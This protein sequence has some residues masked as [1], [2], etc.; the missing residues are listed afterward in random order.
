MLPY[1]APP[2]IRAVSSLSLLVP[3]VPCPACTAAKPRSG[4]PRL[5]SPNLSLVRNA[6]HAAEGRANG[7]K[8][9]PGKRLGAKKTGDEYVIPGNI[10]FRQRGTNWHAGANCALGRDHTV[11]ATQPGYVRYYRNPSIHPTRRYI[12]V[13][14]EKHH[15]LPKPVNAARKR[16]LGMVAIKRRDSETAA[17]DDNEIVT[18]T[19]DTLQNNVTPQSYIVAPGAPAFHPFSP[20]AQGLRNAS[21]NPSAGRKKL[22]LR[23]GYMYRQANWEIGR[24]ADRMAESKNVRERMKVTPRKFVK[25]DRFEAWK[26]RAKKFK[27]NVAE[28]AASSQ[29][30]KKKKGKS[31]KRGRK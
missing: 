7:P 24:V 23:P 15:V 18:G 30:D 12:G 14:L 11:Y 10:I 6:T 4:F 9:G 2:S 5:P 25:K 16:R 21:I 29:G 3:R 1:W 28:R 20:I 8:A 17:E 31:R 13:V 19:P 22:L 27:R 26:A